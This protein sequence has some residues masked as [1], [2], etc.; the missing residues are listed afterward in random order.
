[1][2]RKT[3]GFELKRLDEKGAFIARIARLNAI[4]RDNDVTLPGAFGNSQVAP[5]L[6]AHRWDQ[7]HLGKA[8]IREERDEVLA[9][10]KLNLALD[11]GRALYE[12]LK[13]DM[14]TSPPTETEFSYGYEVKAAEPG[15]F[16]GQRVRFLKSVR[17]LEVSVVLA[18]AGDTA[19]VA[20]KS[21]ASWDRE[22]L[23]ARLLTL[24]R[25][26]QEAWIIQAQAAC[27][28]ANLLLQD[29]AF[30]RLLD[31]GAGK[32]RT[33]AFKYR[34]TT[35]RVEDPRR[36]AATAGLIAATAELRSTEPYLRFF[37]EA[38]PGDEMDFISAHPLVG[39]SNIPA[40]PNVVAVHEKLSPAEVLETVG[41]E[42]AHFAR[43]GL[44]EPKVEEFGRELAR[45]HNLRPALVPVPVFVS[46]REARELRKHHAVHYSP[47]LNAEFFLSYAPGPTPR[48]DSHHKLVAE[49]HPFDRLV[50]VSGRPSPSDN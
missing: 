13:F 45:K 33:G 24:P 41:H 9:Y 39:A 18:G 34:F 19:L 26:Q 1:M 28:E 43:P 44:P 47:L 21:G 50:P 31:D 7:I 3:A 6:V 49:S 37:T 22:E 2:I 30:D 4:D 46:A 14:A 23:V 40:H 48:A 29:I 17:V 36:Q 27:V 42:V 20:V 38:L 5:I 10:G 25:E 32:S 11:A 12:A 35:L 8:A 15:V 16:A